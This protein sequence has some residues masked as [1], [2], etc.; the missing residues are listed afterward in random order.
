EDAHVHRSAGHGHV[1]EGLYQTD[2]RTEETNHRCAARY[3]GEGRE[4]VF[5]FGDFEVGHVLDCVLYVGHGPPD[6]LDTLVNHPGDGRVG[7][8]AEVHGRVHPAFVDEVPYLVHEV[9]V[10]FRGFADGD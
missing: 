6:A 2:D 1:H 4:A 7:R 10:D 3:G 9:L 8:F 5:E